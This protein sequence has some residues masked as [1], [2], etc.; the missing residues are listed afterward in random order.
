[1]TFRYIY[2]FI[3]RF[4]V[5]HFAVFIPWSQHHAVHTWESILNTNI[6]QYT[7][8]NKIHIKRANEISA[9][10]FCRICE[11]IWIYPT[12]AY[13]L[14]IY[15][16]LSADR[17]RWLAIVQLFIEI[18]GHFQNHRNAWEKQSLPS[19]RETS[20]IR[21][22]HCFWELADSLQPNLCARIL[23]LVNTNA[24]LYKSAISIPTL[25]LHCF[26]KFFF[27]FIPVSYSKRI[28]PAPL[29]LILIE[30]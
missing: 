3:N 22:M 9:S 19:R 7:I 15:A 24:W 5:T 11:F 16:S 29:H 27:L 4:Q 21:S 17:A 13:L 25:H 6:N 2:T 26:V 28:L 1:M 12:K 10:F 14:F 18:D 23:L 20:M 30:V 8:M